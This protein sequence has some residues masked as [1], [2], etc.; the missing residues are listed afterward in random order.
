M[1]RS[2]RQ[3]HPDRLVTRGDCFRQKRFRCDAAESRLAG[4]HFAVRRDRRRS[5]CTKDSADERSRVISAKGLIAAPFAIAQALDRIRVAGIA[6]QQKAAQ[7]FY[8]DNAATAQQPANLAQRIERSICVAGNIGKTRT[9]EIQ[10]EPA[11]AWAHKAGR[12]L[13]ERG[14]AGRWHL[15]TQPNTNRTC[16]SSPSLFSGDRRGCLSRWCSA[17][18][19]WWQLVKG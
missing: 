14:N 19:S 16:G 18:R 11:S 8:G 3:H 17:G 13:A 15:H 4:E 6:G 1:Q 10:I 12:R 9:T 2:V 7:A 5:G